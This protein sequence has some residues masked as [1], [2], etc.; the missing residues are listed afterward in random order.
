VFPA[1]ARWYLAG[2]AVFGLLCIAMQLSIQAHAQQQAQAL[3]QAWGA[4]A[5][6]HI[7]DVRYHL[8][9][10]GLILRDIRIERGDDSIAIAQ[11]LLRA[12]PKLLTG[13]APRIGVIDISGLRAQITRAGQADVW[14]HERYLQQIWQAATAL[15]VH[16]GHIRL[17]V[18]GTE[19]PPLELSGVSIRQRLQYGIRSIAGS[20]RIQQ[21]GVHWRWQ[22][23]AGSESPPAQATHWRTK[24][25]VQWQRL[26]AGELTASMALKQ[27]AGHLSG[28][29]AWETHSQGNVSQQ[30]VS[31]DGEMQLDTGT[32]SEATHA[33][34]VQ[35]RA[36]EAGGRWQMDVDATAWPLD[37]WSAAL[38]RLGGRQLITAQMDGNTHW[39]GHPGDWDIQSDNGFIQ[40]VTYARP[41]SSGSPAWY[42][43]RIHYTR[44]VIHTATHQLQVDGLDMLD[45]R[46]V[47]QTQ[48]SGESLAGNTAPEA[49]WDI[50]ADQINVRNMMLALAL[51]QGKVTLTAL[52]G[53]VRSPPGK[54]LR[55]KLHTHTAA[56]KNTAAVEEQGSDAPPL[57][58][59]RGSAEK[60]SRGQL[61]S[62]SINI[63][64]QQVPVAS[65]RPLLPLQDD[66]DRA[67]KLTG[68]TDFRATVSVNQGQWQMQGKAEVRDL[69]LAHGGDVLQA[70]Q[71]S[72]RF[73]PVGMGLESQYIDSI[74]AQGWQY[75]AALHPLALHVAEQGDND[76]DPAGGAAWWVSTLRNNQIA[77]DQLDM[78]DGQISVGQRQA[79]WADHV[80]ISMAGIQDAQWS[81]ITV[82]AAVGGSDFKLAGQWQA[83]SDT[84]RF[85][86]DVSLQQAEPFFLHNWMAASGMPRLIQGRLSASLHLQDGPVPDSY[87]GTVQ[88]Q[89]LQGMT[90][91][92]IFTSDP[93]LPRTGY[94]TSELLQRLEQ[95]PGVIALQYDLSGLWPEQALTLERLGLSMQAAMHEAARGGSWREQAN[96][97]QGVP[98]AAIVARIRLHGRE[99]LSLNERNRLSG[100]VHSLRKHPERIIFLRPKWKGP[101][102]TAETQQ[103]IRRTQQLI[104]QYM[105]H[106]HIDKNRIFSVWPTAGDQVA[107]IGSVQVE[108]GSAGG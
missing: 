73:G 90:E 4:R 84:Q 72:M 20:A 92:G 107:E 55:F 89:L 10:N 23:L 29:L 71:I 33:H 22:M 94:S 100:V 66:A 47:L 3:V 87:Q 75:I 15:T 61:I 49:V 60:N 44:A 101:T 25:R 50:N 8:L 36:S 99:R 24:G 78:E 26:D 51:P 18:N 93:M 40:D 2:I 83:L 67:V 76:H 48:R 17:Y 64:G 52:D 31:I 27:I 106:R 105:T 88:C 30:S 65:L 70:D 59:L 74:Q 79:L 41:D 39:Q 77:I 46:L 14:K 81:D 68:R 102:L 57:W 95:S 32:D 69:N 104:E 103:R 35:F 6:V 28:D 82:A 85:R 7:G 45:S 86:G 1:A 11:M 12:N 53:Q 9:R 97:E 5:S 13:D 63:R 42:W 34:H 19:A 108:A 54:P 21:G 43:S 16:D 96:V 98:D 80:H 62:A 37:P 56:Q 58:R 38:P 91:T